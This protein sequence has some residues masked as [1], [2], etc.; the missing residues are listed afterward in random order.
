MNDAHL[1]NQINL[2]AI[3]TGQLALTNLP[4]REAYLRQQ[5]RLFPALNRI[6][7]A[8][9]QPSYMGLGY[10][11]RDRSTLFLSTWNPGGGTSNWKIDAQNQRHLLA[12]DQSD[13]PRLQAWYQDTVKAGRAVWSNISTSVT[14]N[15]LIL[16]ASQPIY[17]AD[18]TLLGVVKTDIELD[19]IS[20]FLNQISPSGQSFLIERDGTLIAAST[21]GPLAQSRAVAV[22][23]RIQASNSSDPVVRATAEYL[24]QAGL[25]GVQNNQQFDFQVKNEQQFVEVMPFRDDRG[26]D[27]LVVITLPASDFMAEINANT[28]NTLLLSAA[29]LGVAILFGSLTARLVT[30]PVKQFGRAARAIAGGEFGQQVP[31]DLNVTE[32][33]EMS[34]S[35]NQMAAQLQ[36]SFSQVQRT[37]KESDAKLN[38][39]LN[40][41][42]ACI[43]SYRIHD[44]SPEHYD[45]RG[46]QTKG[47]NYEYCSAGC[48]QV[49]GYPVEEFTQTRHLWV[50][51]VHP[52]DWQTVLLPRYHRLLTRQTTTDEYR[53]R[54][55]NG[56]WRWISETAASRWEAETQSW[57]VTVVSVDITERKQVEEQLRNNEALLKLAQQVVRMGIWQMD[58]VTLEI[59][60]SQELYA[61]FGLDPAQKYPLYSDV[62]SR[63][64]P[65]DRIVVQERVTQAIQ[66]GISYKTDLRILHV[67]GST[68][69]LEVYGEAVH[70]A[71]G[72]VAKLFGTALDITDRKLAELELQQAK[73]AAEIASQAKSTFLANMSHELRTPLNVILGFAQLMNRETSLTPEQQDHLIMIQQSG[74]HLLT[75][76]NDILDLSKI[77]ANRVILDE[78][79]FDLIALIYSLRDMFRLQIEAQQ[80]QFHLELSPDLP[81]HIL[82]DQNKV[83]QVLTNLLSNAIKFTEQ[84]SVT[85][86]V[87]WQAEG[88]RKRDELTGRCSL[89][90]LEVEDTGVGIPADELP[91][92]FNAFVQAQAGRKVGQG[93]GLGLT[94]SR[95]FVRLMGGD[96]QVTSVPGQGSTFYVTLPVQHDVSATVSAPQLPQSLSPAIPA[97]GASAHDQALAILPAVMPTCWMRD[98]RQAAIHCDSKTID[99][100]IAEIPPEHPVLIDLLSSLAYDFRF[101]VIQQ[102]A[103]QAVEPNR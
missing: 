85:L 45:A 35:F 8:T 103:T 40:S 65:D 54:H 93:T 56:D 52:E 79:N 98:L 12:T 29:A 63:I 71:A 82:A 53:F 58:T 97:P 15:N 23:P 94:I 90:C 77:E 80:I 24:Y 101:D 47:W 33:D 43:I 55:R 76:I 38:D 50:S 60:W 51:R 19:Q 18:R 84:G 73:E 14:P 64:H 11:D 95:K 27:W 91:L 96:I 10:G 7:I 61:L 102:V 5:L 69:Y 2:D 48:E 25:M 81:R 62:M 3:A 4:E 89:I 39:I 31:I 88:P 17:S 72:Q 83:R 75:L 87:S 20:Q 59:V 42:I 100:L 57:V 68:R 34:Q 28:R 13:D 9:E 92:I 78:S 86:R 41:A 70:N 1:V 26:I 6:S 22:S 36:T 49:F 46:Y 74:E 44:T 66:Q 37:L 99:R 67:D 21:A 30:R 16:S 32:L